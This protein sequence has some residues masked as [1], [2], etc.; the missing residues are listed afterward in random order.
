MLMNTPPFKTSQSLQPLPEPGQYWT[1][2]T[3]SL[4]V[5]AFQF[6]W[7]HMTLYTDKRSSYWLLMGHKN[8]IAET[9][10]ESQGAHNRVSGDVPG[11]AEEPMAGS[12]VGGGSSVAVWHDATSRGDECGGGRASQHASGRVLDD[13]ET[14]LS[15]APGGCAYC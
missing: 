1:R 14:M 8:Y 2:D 12:Q 7:V 5:P 15:E 9:V 3:V 4:R 13:R 6:K 10:A 11:A